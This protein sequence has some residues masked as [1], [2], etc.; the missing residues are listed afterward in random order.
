[1]TQSIAYRASDNTFRHSD[2]LNEA[3]EN[4]CPFGGSLDSSIVNFNFFKE[5]EFLLDFKIEFTSRSLYELV[6]C[7]LVQKT[8]ENIFKVLCPNI[9]IYFKRYSNLEEWRIE[10][11]S[12]PSRLE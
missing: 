9:P 1:M 4:L 3:D 11:I 10:K 7:L 6:C 2:D 5:I 8:Q 12:V